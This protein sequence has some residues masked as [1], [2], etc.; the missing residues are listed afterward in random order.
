MC[1]CILGWGGDDCSV[2]G[3]IRANPR[4]PTATTTSAPTVAPRDNCLNIECGRNSI[5][6][7]GACECLPGFSGPKCTKDCP[8]NCSGRGSCSVDGVCNCKSGFRGLS[9]SETISRNGRPCA[10][11]CNIRGICYDGVYYS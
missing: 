7:N 3:G 4:Q 9:C 11:N 2:K 5:C 8:N 6:R 10:D 1:E